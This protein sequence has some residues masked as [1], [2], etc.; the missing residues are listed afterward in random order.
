MKLYH[1][2]L[3]ELA[4][5]CASMESQLEA[6]IATNA[7][8]PDGVTSIPA[9]AL[10]LG[11]PVV[12]G[13]GLAHDREKTMSAQKDAVQHFSSSDGPWSDVTRA[14]SDVA[15]GIYTYYSNGLRNL[16]SVCGDIMRAA[17]HPKVLVAVERLKRS[18]SNDATQ[19][20]ADAQKWIS[21]ARSTYRLDCQSM[22]DMW[23]AYCAVDFDPSDDDD[24][25]L[26]V[27]QSTASRLQSDMR[28]AMQ[29]LLDKL[30]AIRRSV[31]QL[32]TKSE[33]R[34]RGQQI[35][36]LLEKEDSRQ[37]RLKSNEVWRGVNNPMIYFATEYG[38]QRH[39]AKWSENGCK[40]PVS[41]NVD[42]R[43][44]GSGKTKP[45]CIVPETCSVIEFKPNSPT[46]KTAG[47]QAVSACSGIVAPYYNRMWKSNQ[48][49]PEALGGQVVVDILAAKCV[50]GG[51][52]ALSV[53]YQT[54][55]VCK[56]QYECIPD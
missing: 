26:S 50:K 49:P 6:F 1:H 8:D 46:G 23:D 37:M 30:P 55:D 19:I 43:F 20:D 28:S 52:I 29:P 33:T 42:A 16:D 34:A 40:V 39:K 15:G 18:S 13:M 4:P 54:Y 53:S 17:S 7:S 48:R 38:K 31:E 41:D 35:M 22:K 27:A 44:P 10:Q 2:A 5:K 56:S 9:F 3:D 36:S 11:T 24:R 51:D 12:T 25:D 47:D 45:D 32:L 14:Y 21:D